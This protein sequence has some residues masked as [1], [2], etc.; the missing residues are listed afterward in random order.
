MF[1]CQATLC[2]GSGVYHFEKLR[3]VQQTL[4]QLDT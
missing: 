3:I 2:V 4:V 1:A